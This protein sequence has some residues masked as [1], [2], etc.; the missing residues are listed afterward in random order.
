MLI[1]PTETEGKDVLDAFCDAMIKIA[2]LA[3]E[4]PDEIKKCPQNTLRGRLDDV[5]AAKTPVLTFAKL[6][7]S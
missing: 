5:L 7:C 3:K 1:E 6:K 4:N 2:K